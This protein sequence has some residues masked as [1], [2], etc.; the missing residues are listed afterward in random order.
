MAKK[1]VAVIIG[2]ILLTVV[3]ASYSY[4]KYDNECYK[5]TCEENGV[6]IRAHKTTV[7]VAYKEPV[8][9]ITINRVDEKKIEFRISGIPY[10]KIQRGDCTSYKYSGPETLL[11]ITY[12]FYIN[13]E[14]IIIMQSPH[15]DNDVAKI[16]GTYTRNY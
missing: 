13:D 8:I 1:I 3:I 5:Y 6:S 10:S 16:V 2:I 15:N 9:D 4:N 7:G 14:E 12:F 11:D